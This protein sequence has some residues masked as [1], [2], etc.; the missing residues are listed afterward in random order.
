MSFLWT[1]KPPFDKTTLSNDKTKVSCTEKWARKIFGTY[2]QYQGLTRFKICQYFDYSKM[3][4][5]WTKKPS[6]YKLTWSNDKT[7]VSCTEKWAWKIRETSD[8]NHGLTRLKICKVFAIVKWRYYGLKS[9]LLTK[10]H[11]QTTKLRT[12]IQKSR[13]ER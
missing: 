1:K 8:Q 4:F 2:D 3:S 11:D 6:F 13:L 9:L 12:L 5:L 10:Q 7:K